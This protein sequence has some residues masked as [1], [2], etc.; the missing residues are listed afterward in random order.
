MK[1]GRGEQSF[2]REMERKSMNFCN[3]GIRGLNVLGSRCITTTTKTSA[4]CARLKRAV[5]VGGHLARLA[6]P[7]DCEPGRQRGEDVAALLIFAG[8]SIRKRSLNSEPEIRTARTEE[9]F[10]KAKAIT[11]DTTRPIP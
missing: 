1:T 11:A 10:D 5:L 6:I 8:L 3:F 2:Y 4:E 7:K 9:S